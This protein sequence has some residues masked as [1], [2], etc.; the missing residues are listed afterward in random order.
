M[1]HEVNLRIYRDDDSGIVGTCPSEVWRRDD[2]G[3]FDPFWQGILIFHD[4]FEHYFEHTHAAFCGDNAHNVSGEVTAH[5]HLIY[6]LHTLECNRT[7]VGGGYLD[8]AGILS[9]TFGPMYDAI[10]G[11]HTQ[12]GETFQS[13]LPDNADTYPDFL[14]SIINKHWQK[15]QDTQP[16]TKCRE[17][18]ARAKRYKKSVTR[19][20]LATHYRTGYDMA[21]ALV[22]NNRHNM[23]ELNEFIDFFDQ[24]CKA[25]P[26]ESALLFGDKIT[27]TVRRSKAGLIRWSAK[28][29]TYEGPD[30]SLKTMLRNAHK[31]AY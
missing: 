23:W 18:R 4:V 16:D 29:I 9:G 1:T 3:Q 30:L 19:Q 22:P 25:I 7:N 10:T 17:Q 31:Y 13:D 20:A 27:V 6:Y 2:S 15:V 24:F 26:A 12:Y 11:G 21:A 5:G 14:E 8:D 28:L